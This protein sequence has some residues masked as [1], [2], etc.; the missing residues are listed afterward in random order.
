[1]AS[2]M[3]F[4]Q[5]RLRD[6]VESNHHLCGREPIENT[7]AIGAARNIPV[8]D[9]VLDVEVIGAAEIGRQRPFEVPHPIPRG[10]LSPVVEVESVSSREIQDAMIHQ[11]KDP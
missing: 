2:G 6:I 1:M 10:A 7:S 5:D 3:S 8:D 4:T 9:V 11:T